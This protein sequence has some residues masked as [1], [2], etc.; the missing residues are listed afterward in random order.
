MELRILPS[1]ISDMI[2]AGE[3]VQRPAS[4]VKELMENA[5]DAGADDI[6]VIVRDSGRTL[7]QVIDNGCG[8]SPDDAVLCF[9]RHATSKLATAEDLSHILTFGFRGEALAS[10]A[11]IARVTLKTRREE[12]ENGVEVQFEASNHSSTREVACPKG[13]SFAVRDIF[14]N[15][16]A[17]R[18]FLK[19]DKV[20]LKHII[21][22]FTRVALSHPEIAFSLIH[23]ERD[24]FSLKKAKSL[25][26]RIMNLLGSSV[27]DDLAD[28]SAETSVAR[29][30]G[31]VGRPEAARKTVG[32]QFFFVNG[33]YFRSPYLSKAVTNAYEGLVPE[34]ATPSWFIFLEVD[35]A[36]MD[37]NIHPT[38]TEIKFSED[39]VLFQVIYACVKESLGRYAEAGSIDFDSSASEIPVIGRK[40]EE[41]RPVSAPV[42]AP[43]P[44]YNPFGGETASGTPSPAPSYSSYI[45]RKE[46]YGRL[47]EQQQ[48]LPS[49]QTIVLDGRYI[50]S[51]SRSGLMFVH[52]RRARERLLFDRFLKI[53]SEGG[54]FAQ[55]T[56]F[57][58]E[59]KVGAGN[60]ALFEEKAETLSSL[61]FD[62]SPFGTDSVVVNAVPEGYSASPGKVETMIPDLVRILSDE[63][64]SLGAAMASSMAERFAL[65]GAAGSE[66][67]SSP[68]EAKALLEELFRSDNPEFTSS[69]RKIMVVEKVEDIDKRF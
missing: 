37:V 56:L 61:G 54:H 47:F 3:V 51:R 17:R 8:M 29:I 63:S 33:R 69:G 60:V 12:D 66:S 30:T 21:D 52:V 9:E 49:A 48:S 65:L 40:F 46:D 2:A 58:V 59:V 7:V 42:M 36:S 27:A 41:Y 14:Y 32:N 44:S 25:K 64:A 18:K 43:D 26:F 50:V 38:K 39:S 16:P 20:E 53:F 67:L 28:I 34:G 57:P 13:S 11:A 1:N 45:E 15:V 6:K 19:S 5:V 22:E 4:V 55:T 62:I 10:I 23:N 35:P 31:F 24:V 68:F